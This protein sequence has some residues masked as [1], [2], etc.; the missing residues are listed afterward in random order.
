M[1]MSFGGNVH[2]FLW[3]Q[4]TGSEGRHMITFSSCYHFI[5][6][7]ERVMDEGCH[8]LVH[9]WYWEAFPHFAILVGLQ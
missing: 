1:R 9:T 4:V 7:Q 5:L 8:S 6:D 2:S 3:E